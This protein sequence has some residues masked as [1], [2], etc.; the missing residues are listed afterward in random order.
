MTAFM[1]FQRGAYGGKLRPSTYV[2]PFRDLNYFF[3]GFFWTLLFLDIRIYRL[4]KCSQKMRILSSIALVLM[5]TG[6]LKTN[7]TINSKE[8]QTSYEAEQACSNEAERL[9]TD[10]FAFDEES[11]KWDYSS[12]YHRCRH[13]EDA[14]QYLLLFESK[15]KIYCTSDDESIADKSAINK[16]LCLNQYEQERGF[17]YEKLPTKVKSRFKY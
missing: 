12:P 7:Q 8:Y 2:Y 5:L 17:V 11:G 10:E 3:L 6:C 4:K 9:G 13:E 14:R 1:Q 16:T 15:K